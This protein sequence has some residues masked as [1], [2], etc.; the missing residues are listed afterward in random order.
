MKQTR[1]LDN[2]EREMR[3]GV[4]T[5]DGFLG[6]D[7]RHLVDILE[8]D[9]AEVRRL[10][11]THERIADRMQELSEA[12]RRGLGEPISVDPHFE[13]RVD[14]VRGKL[15]CPFH[16]GIFPKT[17]TIVRN[18]DRNSRITYTDLNIHMVREHGF[19][20]GEGS[21]F[22]VAPGELVAVLEMEPGE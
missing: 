17:N 1:K 4:I 18:L 13:V 2:V 8:A 21:P 11:L 19:Y 3:P 9:D 14:G 15:P 12:G 10:G 16:E 5:R 6:A 22:R 7:R 20:E